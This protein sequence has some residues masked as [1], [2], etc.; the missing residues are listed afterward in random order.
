MPS[1][2]GRVV[3]SWSLSCQ[4]ALGSPCM[5]THRAEEVGEESMRATEVVRC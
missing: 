3:V 2:E 5:V 1:T 4:H